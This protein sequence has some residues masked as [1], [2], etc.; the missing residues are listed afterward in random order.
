MDT[1]SK[2]VALDTEKA[3][4]EDTR[5]MEKERGLKG[6]LDNREPSIPWQQ[7]TI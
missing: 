7:V 6:R 5:D 3:S 4:K 2:E 1:Y